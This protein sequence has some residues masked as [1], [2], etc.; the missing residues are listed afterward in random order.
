MYYFNNNITITIVI[1][2]SNNRTALI[3]HAGLLRKYHAP[4]RARKCMVASV[5]E[6]C[7]WASERERCTLAFESKSRWIQWYAINTHTCFWYLQIYICV[8][9]C[10]LCAGDLLGYGRWTQHREQERREAEE[11]K[12]IMAKLNEEIP[13]EASSW[14]QIRHVCS[15]SLRPTLSKYFLECN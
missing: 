9:M 15:L 10:I 7:A 12:I 14:E 4:T 3:Y 2:I 6:R 11:M 13:P 1:V 5:P 8:C